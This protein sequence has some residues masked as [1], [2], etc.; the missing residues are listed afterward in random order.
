MNEPKKT[1]LPLNSYNPYDEKSHDPDEKKLGK[2]YN[3]AKQTQRGSDQIVLERI[4]TEKQEIIDALLEH[5]DRLNAQVEKLG[6]IPV[7]PI[8]NQR[9]HSNFLPFQ[10][11]LQQHIYQFSPFSYLTPFLHIK[12]EMTRNIS[13]NNCG[14]QVKK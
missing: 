8:Q 14:C 7:S 5:I 10:C 12:Q 9:I 4:E 1:I 3:E 6:S 11:S 13:C 2:L